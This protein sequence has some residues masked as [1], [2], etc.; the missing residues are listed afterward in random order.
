MMSQ[1]LIKVYIDYQY[2]SVDLQD[3]HHQKNLLMW[4][5]IFWMYAI[6]THLWQ[7]EFCIDIYDFDIDM[8]VVVLVVVDTQIY[9]T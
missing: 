1:V 9:I 5:Y 2:Y 8:F 3:N 4:H 7:N 6:H